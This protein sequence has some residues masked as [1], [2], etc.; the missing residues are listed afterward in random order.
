MIT[1]RLS[2]RPIP[3]PPVRLYRTVALTFLFITIV[4]LGFV[5]FAMLKK[6][7]IIIMAREDT[8]SV[9]TIITAE[10]QKQGVK[11]INSIVTSTQFYWLEKY[12]PTAVK[13]V[14]STSKGQVIIYNKT[15][16][17]QILV[18][19]TRL[20]TPNNVLFR[21]SDR[22]IIPANG[23]LTADVYA[24]KSGS[25]SDIGPSQFTIPGLSTE[26]QK[27]I[28]AESKTAMVGGSGTTKVV[29]ESDLKAAEMDF[30]EKTKQAFLDKFVSSNNSKTTSA[31]FDQKIVNVTSQHISPS[32]KIG[33]ETNEFTI[34]GTSTLTVVFYNRQEL[35]ETL[36]KEIGSNIDNGSEKI[37][38]LNGEP[39][40]S[41]ES[42]DL[43]NA[44][45]RLSVT[46]QALVTLD[47]NAPLLS[48][49]NFLNKNKSEL[50]R[51]IV[52]L[53]HVISMNIKFTPSWITKTPGVPDKIKV[54]VKNVK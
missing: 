26:K 40:I 4:L 6:T 46:A 41:I 47:A 20:L 29:S 36:N 35:I 39:Q 11:S 43:S 8:K 23:Q 15:N 9:K 50:E 22:V 19:T 12:T 24:D 28:Y 10:Q 7:E 51:Y 34:S 32:A 18:K 2:T 52:G 54:I 31:D 53:P 21:L 27:L 44:N 30:M 25:T 45:A 42:V 3:P 1:R 5:I 13:N 49:E 48:K 38:S 33:Q 14:P 37:L 16:E 17:N